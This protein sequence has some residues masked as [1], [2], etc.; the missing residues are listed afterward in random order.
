MGICFIGERNFEEFILEY[1]EPR[2]GNFVSIETGKVMGE[3]KGWF[4]FTLGQRARIGG[5][6]DAWFVVDKDITT[7]DLFVAPTTNHPALLRDTLRTERFHWIAEEPSA[8]LI[9]TKMMDC[10]FRFQHQMPLT[11]CTVTLN[12]DGSVWIMTAKPLR[13]LTPGQFAVL[14]KGDECLGSGKIISLG[15]SEYTLQQGRQRLAGKPL[16]HSSTSQS[17]PLTWSGKSQSEPLTQTNSSQPEPLTQTGIS[18]PEPLTQTCTSEAEPHTQTAATKIEPLTR[19]GTSQTEPVTK[20]GATQTEPLTQRSA[21]QK[22]P[23]P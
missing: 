4:T 2:P 6:R 15:P 18:Q 9:R 7:N 5:Q 16:T 10:Q 8:E 22:E 21:T 17:E 23:S 19:T 20:T 11:P 1:L 12:Q 13:A 14:Y 3:H